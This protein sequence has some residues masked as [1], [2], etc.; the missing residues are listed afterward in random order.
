MLHQD[1]S[2]VYP[3]SCSSECNGV[4]VGC[5][6]PRLYL[7]YNLCRLFLD[8]QICPHVFS[9]VFNIKYLL[10]ILFF[11]TFTFCVFDSLKH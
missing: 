1:Y 8:K 11:P 6:H 10:M 2:T 9:S 5:Y 4:N 3:K 7:M